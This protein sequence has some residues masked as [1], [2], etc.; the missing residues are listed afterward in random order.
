MSGADRHSTFVPFLS[1]TNMCEN[2]GSKEYVDLP[3]LY[4]D[5]SF[6]LL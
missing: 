6:V 1:P 4:G 5:W 3:A 2:L